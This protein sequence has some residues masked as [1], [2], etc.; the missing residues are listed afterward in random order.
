MDVKLILHFISFLLKRKAHHNHEGDE[1]VFFPM[2]SPCV[3]RKSRTRVIS[4][5][6]CV[7][8]RYLHNAIPVCICDMAR[9]SLFLQE[10][11]VQI[12][13]NALGSIFTSCVCN[14][15]K[16]TH[17]LVFTHSRVMLSLGSVSIAIGTAA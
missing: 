4:M 9:M 3:T 10:P 2:T 6:Y 14:Y 11:V 17:A 5:H 1:N 16:A 8:A 12:V 13:R 7:N 15:D